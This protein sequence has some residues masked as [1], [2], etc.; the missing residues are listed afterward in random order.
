M[1]LYELIKS[2]PKAMQEIK[3]NI[4]E[5]FLWMDMDTNELCEEEPETTNKCYLPDFLLN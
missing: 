1:T 3:N 2:H 5:G 4:V